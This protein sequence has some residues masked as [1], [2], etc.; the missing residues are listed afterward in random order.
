MN[1]HD[2]KQWIYLIFNG[3]ILNAYSVIIIQK[4]KFSL[5]NC[6][7]VFRA[8]RLTHSRILMYVPIPPQ[9]LFYYLVW[10]LNMPWS[11]SSQHTL[12][13]IFIGTPRK[14]IQFSSHI[15]PTMLDIYATHHAEIAYF[16]FS[17]YPLLIVNIFIYS[18]L[19]LLSLRNEESRYTSSP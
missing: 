16:H 18:H 7:L 10:K 6:R 13:M 5:F 15:R 3:L 2:N 17:Q 8:I 1:C 14:N 12:E 11:I 9:V 19:N 4:W